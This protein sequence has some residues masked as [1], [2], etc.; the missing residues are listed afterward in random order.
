MF[1]E[2]E[3]RTPEQQEHNNR[4]HP[5]PLLLHRTKKEDITTHQQNEILK[6]KSFQELAQISPQIFA[7]FIDGKGAQTFTMQNFN[8]QGYERDAFNPQISSNHSMRSLHV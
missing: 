8:P 7:P 4:L 3:E 6:A 2:L 1:L 5:L